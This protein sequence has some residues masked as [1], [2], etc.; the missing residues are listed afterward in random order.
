MEVLQLA[1]YTGAGEGRDREGSSWR[2]RPSRAQGSTSQNITFL[3]EAFQAIIQRLHARSGVRNLE[4]E[5]SSSAARSRVRSSSKDGRSAKEIT[6]TKVT[7]YLGVPRFR[8]TLAEE[9]E[10]SRR[11]DRTGVDRSGGEILVIEA[12]LMPG[13]GR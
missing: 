11:R 3:D 9:I 2:R 1:G 10:R 5:I 13:K 8:P 7:E 12:T 6:A 4:R